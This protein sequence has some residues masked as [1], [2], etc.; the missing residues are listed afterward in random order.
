M[1][2]YRLTH[3]R[4]GG[5]G[6]DPTVTRFLRET[7]S[8]PSDAG[9]WDGLEARIMARV[10]TGVRSARASAAAGIAPAV[11]WWQVLSVSE[12][13][14]AGAWA[15]GV[16][17]LVAAAAVLQSREAERRVA[18]TAILEAT[19]VAPAAAAPAPGTPLPVIAPGS[20]SDRDAAL[21]YLLSPR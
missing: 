8:P 5:E 10:R 7:H 11:E 13:V 3:H 6:D 9:Y 2:K 1:S 21:R 18:Y 17:A 15:A 16:A 19:A 4:R 12:W 20:S 14:S